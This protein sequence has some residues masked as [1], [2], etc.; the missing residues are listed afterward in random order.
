MAKWPIGFLVLSRSSILA[1][2]SGSSSWGWNEFMDFGQ[3]ATAIIISS[4]LEVISLPLM[5]VSGE[6]REGIVV[7]PGVSNVSRVSRGQMY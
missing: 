3:Q 5:V 2:R 4:S 6:R 7:T 1:A